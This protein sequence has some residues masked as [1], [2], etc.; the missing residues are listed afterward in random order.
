MNEFYL[1][2]LL[3]S[4]R[5]AAIFSGLKNGR[6]RPATKTTESPALISLLKPASSNQVE[7]GKSLS[8]PSMNL[9]M[10]M[11]LRAKNTIY[12]QPFPIKKHPEP[13]K[14]LSRSPYQHRVFNQPI[15]PGTYVGNRVIHLFSG[16][17]P[18][19]LMRYGTKTKRKPILWLRLSGLFL[20]RYAVRQ[21]SALLFQLPPRI[22]RFE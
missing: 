11:N 14:R 18:T 3:I 8:I 16:S 2:Q 5:H 19:L 7:N 21:F 9:S 13:S 22:T 4:L 10:L 20:L 1:G 12:W 6:S 15:R 17:H